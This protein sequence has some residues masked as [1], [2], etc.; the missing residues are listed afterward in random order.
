MVYLADALPGR[1]LD[2]A[3]VVMIIHLK[4]TPISAIASGW[5]MQRGPT[6]N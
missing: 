6:G 3:E 1:A 4:I 2:R 5:P